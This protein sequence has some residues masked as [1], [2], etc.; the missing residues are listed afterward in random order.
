M[1]GLLRYTSPELVSVIA[2]IS[3]PYRILVGNANWF[4]DRSD[5]AGLWTTGNYLVNEV[6]FFKRGLYGDLR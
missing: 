3:D 6:V 5:M 1:P 4:A 2:I